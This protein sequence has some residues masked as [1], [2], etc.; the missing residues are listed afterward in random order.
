MFKWQG[1]IDNEDGD[2]ILYKAGISNDYTKRIKQ[3][4]K[5]FSEN[6]HTKGFCYKN[7]DLYEDARCGS[8][9]STEHLCLV[10]VFRHPKMS[11]KQ[12]GCLR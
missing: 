1:R 2:T 6:E 7:Q 9:L 10:F 11:L 5:L 12:G 8:E 3:H 4:R